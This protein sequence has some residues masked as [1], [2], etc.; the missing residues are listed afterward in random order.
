MGGII[1]TGYRGE[2]VVLLYNTGPHYKI[3]KGDKI[4]QLVL[5]P[6]LLS[7]MELQ[8]LQED[9][10]EERGTKGFGSSGV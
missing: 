7:G 3:S 1:D 10:V 6:L 5:Y 8:E 9:T 2:L 4:A